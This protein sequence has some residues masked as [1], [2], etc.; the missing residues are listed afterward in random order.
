M[1]TIGCWVL[2]AMAMALLSCSEDG[3][4]S[5]GMACC[6]L[7]TLCGSC[8]CES[9]IEEMAHQNSHSGCQEFLDQGSMGCPAITEDDALALCDAGGGVAADEE[10]LICVASEELLVCECALGGPPNPL[11]DTRMSTCNT[12]LFSPATVCC[13]SG[14]GGVDRCNCGVVTCYD[15]GTDC[16]CS[17]AI[18]GEGQAQCE[19]DRYANCCS[20]TVTGACLCSDAACAPGDTPVANCAASDAACDASEVRVTECSEATMSAALGSG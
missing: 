6:T 12:S 10:R 17:T 16:E 15:D 7:R 20:S 19:A 18:R 5:S 1:K 11:L 8:A 14:S 3:A 9:G 4:S 2:G 13:V